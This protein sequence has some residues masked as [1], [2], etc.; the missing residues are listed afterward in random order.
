MNTQNSALGDDVTIEEGNWRLLAT[1]RF[2]RSLPPDRF[3]FG[4]WVGTDWK[5]MQDLSCGTTACV[6]GWAPQVPELKHLGLRILK[7][8]NNVVGIGFPGEENGI[9]NPGTNL[10]TACK[11]FGVT[12]TQAHYLFL[13]DSR[14]FNREFSDA[15]PDENAS[16]VEVAAHIERFVASRAPS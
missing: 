9:S 2:L 7:N 16:A 14:G 12:Y 6:M 10:R 5:G 1:A 11:V 3:D 4:M 15:S 8:E 13:P